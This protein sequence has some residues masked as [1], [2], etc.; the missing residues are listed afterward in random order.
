M[1]RYSY[2]RLNYKRCVNTT[3]NNNHCY[4]SDIIDK[5]LAN[6]QLDSKIQDI[7]LTPQNYNNPVRYIESEI[8][9]ENISNYIYPIIDVELKIIIIETDNNIFG[10]E[11]SS[12]KK[13]K[14]YIKYDS[15]S[16]VL[17]P[18]NSGDFS[19]S[20]NQIT[21]KLSSNVPTQKR[22]YI[23]LVDVL[24]AVGGLMETINMIFSIIC[25]LI[26]DILY[27]KSLVNNL[28]SFD[29]NKK[30]IILKNDYSKIKIEDNNINNEILSL[31]KKFNKWKSKNKKKRK[32]N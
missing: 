32:K 18:S 19:E 1:E 10:F 28:F 6:A 13:E 27:D 14:K 15:F 24:G 11:T 23:Q 17:I 20:L 12:K 16:L 9:S 8:I 31:N 3:E 7:E 4:P 26:V 21:I 22:T 30:I 5:Y 29:L 2:I 25:S